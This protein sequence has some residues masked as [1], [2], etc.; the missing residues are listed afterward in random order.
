MDGAF[1]Q[2]SIRSVARR[3]EH[4]PCDGRMTSPVAGLAQDDELP[5]LGD[6]IRAQS[7]ND[8]GGTAAVCARAAPGLDAMADLLCEGREGGRLLDRDRKSVALS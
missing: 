7:V 5:L 3:L 6:R 8:I 1:R 4:R 2:S